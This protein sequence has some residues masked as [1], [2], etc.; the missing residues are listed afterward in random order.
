MQKAGGGKGLLPETEVMTT[1]AKL[2]DEVL[3]HVFRYLTPESL[4]RA[5][6]VCR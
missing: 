1:V 4:K 3:L 2:S 5:M 6:Q